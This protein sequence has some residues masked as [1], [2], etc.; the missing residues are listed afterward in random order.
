MPAPKCPL[1][2]ANHWQRDPH[3]WPDDP[4]PKKE[5][6]TIPKP[7]KES[8]QPTDNEEL[9]KRKRVTTKEWKKQNPERYREYM[10]EYMKRRRQKAK[11]K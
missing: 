5:P 1:C 9:K 10:R 3:I 4:K 11:Q 6:K 2:N 7:E 8:V